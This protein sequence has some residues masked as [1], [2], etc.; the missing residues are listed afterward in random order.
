MESRT[1]PLDI[2]GGLL[3]IAKLTIAM[4]SSDLSTQ[5]FAIVFLDRQSIRS[6]RRERRLAILHQ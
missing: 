2:G 1:T 6:C 5:C 4:R 3:Q